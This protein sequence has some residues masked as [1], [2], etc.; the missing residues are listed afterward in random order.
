[1][2]PSLVEFIPTFLTVIS[3][4]GVISPNT[5]K[6]AADDISP[7]TLISIP[8]K[9][10]AVLTVAVVPSDLQSIPNWLNIISLWFLLRLGSVTEVSPSAYNPA[11]N[12]DD[13]I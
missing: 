9:S 10:E 11:S 5:K 1:M 8:L 7:G 13:L 4:F 2:M 12:I 3:E 6:Y